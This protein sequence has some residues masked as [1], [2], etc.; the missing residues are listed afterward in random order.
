[1]LLL[2]YICIEIEMNERQK[3]PILITQPPCFYPAHVCPPAFDVTTLCGTMVFMV[4]YGAPSV[5]LSPTRVQP[6][7]QGGRIM[8]G[9]PTFHMKG[10]VKQIQKNG[11]SSTPLWG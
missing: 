7:L 8:G 11:F 5:E 2:Y 10:M 1:M 9:G 4:P 6:S 3:N